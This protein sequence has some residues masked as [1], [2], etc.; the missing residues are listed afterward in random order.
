MPIE[1][2][3]Q[4]VEVIHIALS[5]NLIETSSSHEKILLKYLLQFDVK[6]KRKPNVGRCNILWL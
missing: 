2:F 5:I 1:S 4:Y 6:E 3:S